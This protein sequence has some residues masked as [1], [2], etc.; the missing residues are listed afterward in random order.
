MAR[1]KHD[2]VFPLGHVPAV[3]CV[4]FSA[5]VVIQPASLV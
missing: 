5:V 2:R 1:Q 3:E 4:R